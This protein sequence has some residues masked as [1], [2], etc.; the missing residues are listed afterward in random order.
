L[1]NKGHHID[2]AGGGVENVF[3]HGAAVDDFELA[4]EH[5]GVAAVAGAEGRLDFL[6]AGADALG[7]QQPGAV[8]AGVGPRIAGFLGGGGGDGGVAFEKCAE[9]ISNKPE[10]ADRWRDIL[11]EH[12][13]F[14][15]IRAKEKRV[16]LVWR[17]Q[18]P[19]IYDT[20]N[21]IEI[22]PEEFRALVVEDKK[23]ISRRPL[24]PSEI[25]A[26]IN[27]AISLNE[28]A[29]EQK[30]ARKWWVPIVI[31]VLAFIG[32]LIGA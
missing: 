12:P 30:K 26:L 16:S 11:S 4:H 22:K 29:L 1:V 25:T 24:S 8:M 27:V 9:R 19:K 32:S 21:H 10:D 6:D 7:L 13:E 31:G 20:R 23:R 2:G 3:L 15:R 28:R 17:R 18:H 14:F 5:F